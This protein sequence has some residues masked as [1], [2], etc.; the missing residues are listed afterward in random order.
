MIGY[1]CGAALDFIRVDLLVWWTWLGFRTMSDC[2]L[3]GGL[4]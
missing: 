4:I 1:F 3:F 2:P